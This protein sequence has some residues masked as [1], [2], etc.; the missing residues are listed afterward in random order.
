MLGDAP[1]YSA[2]VYEYVLSRLPRGPPHPSTLLLQHLSQ[3]LLL[4]PAARR[5]SGC[6]RSSQRRGEQ[7]AQAK[8]LVEH[9]GK[10]GGQR[11]WRGV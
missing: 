4:Q 2:I 6:R 1:L 7:S 11:G 10:I 3:L 9:S 8:R 5:N